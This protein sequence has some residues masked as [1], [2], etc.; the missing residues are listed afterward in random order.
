M[1][2]LESSSLEKAIK[3]LDPAIFVK[4]SFMVGLGETKEEVIELL[5]DLAGTGCDIL[6][7]GQYLAPSHSRRHVAVENF[8]SPE[9]FEQYRH[10]GFEA[11][12]KYVISGPLVRS[13]YIAEEGYEEC[14][15][16]LARPASV[17]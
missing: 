1:K 13:S 9:L 14:L 8:V 3:Q 12:F 5:K 15:E 10:L 7:I 2:E 11:G 6:T 4:S 17:N 16:A